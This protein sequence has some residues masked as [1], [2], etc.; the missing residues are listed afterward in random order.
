MRP[1]DLDAGRAFEFGQCSPLIGVKFGIGKRFQNDVEV[2][3]GVGVAFSLVDPDRKAREHEVF[4]DVEVNKFLNNGAFIGTGLS[5]WDLT[6]SDTFTPAWM[7]HLGLPLG[8]SVSRPVHFVGE[9]RLF[10]DGID[11]I[12]SNYLLWAGV[13]VHF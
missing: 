3:G 7:L 8:H 5:L 13:R 9:G 4:I 11:E 12:K 1:A 2:A 10:F 6:R